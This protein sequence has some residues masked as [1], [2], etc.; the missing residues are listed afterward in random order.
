M[1]IIDHAV[2]ATQ[3]HPLDQQIAEHLHAAHP[4]PIDGEIFAL[5]V[6][7]SN[8]LQGGKVAAEAYKLLDG[9]AY[10]T[11][12]L[13]APSHMGTFQ[14]MN[15]CSVNTY[16]TPLGDLP[17]NDR[18]RHELCDEDD[19]IFVD[20]S[21]HFHTDGIDVQLPYLQT[22]LQ[23]FDIVPVV[24]GEESP[25]FCRE[26]GHAIGEISYNRRVLVVASADVLDA[27]ADDM[28][29]FR[30]AFEQADVSRL[31]ILVNSGR[32]Q[33]EGKGPLLVALLAALH[34]RAKNVRVLAMEPS[35]GDT[36]GAIGAVLWR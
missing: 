25:A 22:V 5:I 29:A 13:I 31:M 23:D 12:V 20:D 26:L 32:M 1:A 8:L 3:P 27:S 36:P 21:G 33:I 4:D 6:P 10:D 16:S 11:V 19:D 30:A 2:Y 24:M 14:R 17:V 18:I 7:D 34:R 28:E 35:D 9:R 15:I